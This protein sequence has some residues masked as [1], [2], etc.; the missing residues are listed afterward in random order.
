M[1]IL[2]TLPLPLYNVY[3]TF[4]SGKTKYSSSIETLKP[5]APLILLFV[6]SVLWAGFSK[7]DILSQ[8]PRLYFYTLG[9]IFSNISVSQ[10]GNSIMLFLITKTT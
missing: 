3:A 4:K 6:T 10:I 8:D 7:S 9:T 1:S 5:L 2:L